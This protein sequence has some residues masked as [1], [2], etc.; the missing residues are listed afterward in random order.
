ER[1]AKLRPT[2][3]GR[4]RLAHPSLVQRYRMNVGTIVE[5]PMLK[6]RLVRHA[7]VLAK[8]AAR[9]GAP[10]SGEQKRALAGGRGL[11]EIEEGLIEQLAPGDTCLFA[12]EVL[13]FVGLRET[14]AYA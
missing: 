5:A 9:P 12:G 7:G 6:V 2:A 13:R 10:A 14:E 3:D 11:G 1:F 8:S 4:L